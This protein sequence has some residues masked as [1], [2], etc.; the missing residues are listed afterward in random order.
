M[1]LRH[2]YAFMLWATS[3]EIRFARELGVGW[4]NGNIA[5]L[6]EELTEWEGLHGRTFINW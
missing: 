1:I 2:F 4:G 3:W 6:C 5:R